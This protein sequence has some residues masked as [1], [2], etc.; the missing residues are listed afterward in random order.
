[1]SSDG[2]IFHPVNSIAPWSTEVAGLKSQPAP[3]DIDAS[4]EIDLAIGHLVACTLPESSKT[5]SGAGSKH[6]PARA[7]LEPD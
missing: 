5:R 4:G 3:D 6:G 1:M 2:L 7:P